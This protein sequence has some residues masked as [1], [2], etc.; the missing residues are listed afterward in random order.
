VTPGALLELND[1]HGFTTEPDRFD[2]NHTAVTSFYTDSSHLTG[3][4]KR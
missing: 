2:T 4:I 1:F 3:A